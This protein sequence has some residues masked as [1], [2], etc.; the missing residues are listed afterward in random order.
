MMRLLLAVASMA[1][2]L[3]SPAPT[4]ADPRFA[5]PVR[6]RRR[7]RHAPRPRARIRRFYRVRARRLRHPAQSGRARQGTGTGDRGGDSRRRLDRRSG[8]HKSCADGAAAATRPGSST[9]VRSRICPRSTR[10][11]GTRTEPTGRPPISG[12]SWWAAR[13][14]RTLVLVTHYVNIMT[15]TGRGVAS[16]EVLLLELGRDGTTSVVDEILIGP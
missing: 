11:S 15:L 9:W 6:A 12:N 16:G 10:S 4:S 5:R 2:V 7:R 8:A 1:A 13:R 14:E 3:L